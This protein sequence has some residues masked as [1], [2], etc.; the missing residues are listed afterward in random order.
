MNRNL[1]F[2]LTLCLGVTLILLGFFLAAPIW[3]TT[4]SEISE[5]TVPFAGGMLV[6][7]VLAIFLSPVVYELF[8]DKEA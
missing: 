8:P 1:A 5:P 3:S 7:G 2:T 6:L 4:W